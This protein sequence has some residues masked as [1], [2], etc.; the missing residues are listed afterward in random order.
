[1][2]IMGQVASQAG[3][4]REKVRQGLKTGKWNGIMG[5]VAFKDFDG[6]TNQRK[7]VMLVEQVQNGRHETVWPPDQAAKKPVWPF[8]G[9]K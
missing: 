3:G 9:W 7:A 1:M 2:M 8:P 4:D 5:E 6:Y